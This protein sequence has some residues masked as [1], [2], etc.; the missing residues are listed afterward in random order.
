MTWPPQNQLES[1][2][3]RSIGCGD[4]SVDVTVCSP[5]ECTSPKNVNT[6]AVSQVDAAVMAV[7][8]AVSQHTSTVLEQSEPVHQH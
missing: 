8:R 5:K 3:V 7:P 6:E 1:Q 2:E 4:C